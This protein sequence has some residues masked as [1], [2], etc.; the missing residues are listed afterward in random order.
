MSTVRSIAVSLYRVP[1]LV[2]LTLL[3]STTCKKDYYD[4]TELVLL[5]ATLNNRNEV[6]RLTDTLK[7]TFE[8]PVTMT[9]ETSVT[10]LVNSVQQGLYNINLYQV[11]TLNTD[12]ATGRVLVTRIVSPRALVVSEGSMPPHAIGTISVSTTRPPFRSVLNIIP[13]TKGVYYIQTS[14][15][16]LKVNNSYEAFLRVNLD[17]PDKHWTLAN[18]YIA[19]YSTAPE[20]TRADA[21]GNGPY[22]FRVR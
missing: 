9:S 5:K 13:P 12:P 17:V 22:W 16:A 1:L 19:G 6:I 3:L 20:I 15:G 11:D 2:G 4:G 7:I 21:E 14:K 18:R 10:T 8:V